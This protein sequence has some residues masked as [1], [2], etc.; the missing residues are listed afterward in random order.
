MGAI[1][2]AP[3][4]V[5]IEAPAPVAQVEAVAETATRSE[6][7]AEEAAR[8]A[9]LKAIERARRGLAGTIATSARGVLD[10]LPALASRKTL[11]GE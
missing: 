1:F 9:R 6:E 3:K 7:A 10:P 2:R 5:V 11:L 4:P 8:N